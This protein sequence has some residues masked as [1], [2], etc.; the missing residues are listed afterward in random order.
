MMN[1]G[2]L[3]DCEIT[4]VG[5]KQPWKNGTEKNEKDGGM[6]EGELG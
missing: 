2:S 1:H 6:D 4:S 3:A 5:H